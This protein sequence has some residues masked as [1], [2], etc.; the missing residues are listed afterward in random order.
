M[1]LLLRESPL[2]RACAPDRGRGQLPPPP[3]ESRPSH[4][5]VPRGRQRPRLVHRP[6]PH[7]RML[8]RAPLPG[9]PPGRHSIRRRCRLEEFRHSV[10][11]AVRPRPLRGH[12]LC[13]MFP[14]M[15]RSP[16]GLRLPSTARPLSLLVA[17]LFV[18]AT[19]AQTAER[20][21]DV[22]RTLDG[23]AFTNAVVSSS[24]PA[25]LVVLYDGGG[26]KIYFTNLA[27]NL[28]ADYGYD[29][30]QAEAYESKD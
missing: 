17:F 12:A 27:D 10:S 29:P 19:G 3:D 22:L 24:T 26:R 21:F 5:V 16:S 18:C 4:L 14:L 6:R 25:Y 15:T 8:R 7:R 2:P 9:A 13:A 11:V 30:A 28:R 1:V 23:Q 20:R